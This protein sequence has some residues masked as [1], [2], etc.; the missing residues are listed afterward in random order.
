M[1][2]ALNKIKLA[3]AG[4]IKAYADPIP[5]DQMIVDGDLLL[6]Y[7]VEDGLIKQGVLTI[8]HASK[9]HFSLEDAETAAIAEVFGNQAAMFIRVY[10]KRGYCVQYAFPCK[11][12]P[13][14]LE[15][16]WGMPDVAT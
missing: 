1:K 14:V 7:V 3:S 15:G 5:S 10:P 4:K 13:A 11:P 12:E 9:E 8:S 6:S 16:S 2:E